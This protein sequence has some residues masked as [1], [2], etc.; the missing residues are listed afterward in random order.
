ME[1]QGTETGQRGT[2]C[3]VWYN[4][5]WTHAPPADLEHV[6]YEMVQLHR[7]WERAW[8][9][10][11]PIRKLVERQDA[12]IAE[13]ALESILVHA[14]NLLDFFESTRR[15]PLPLGIDGPK[16]TTRLRGL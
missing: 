11:K 15:R 8:L 10:E 12:E 16:K 9:D 5:T 3:L 13:N 7:L 2:D 6:T 4:Q 14:R 1:K